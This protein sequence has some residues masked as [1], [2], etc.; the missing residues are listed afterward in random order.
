MARSVEQYQQL[1]IALLPR[2]AAWP[3]EPDSELGKLMLGVAEECRRIEQRID[4]LIEE[5]DPRTVFELIDEWE[6]DWGLPSKCVQPTTLQ[7]RRNVLTNKMI[8]IPN[9]SRQTYIDR[10]AQL[11]Y[12]ITITEYAA[13]DTVPGQPQI[14]AA[15]A[16]YVLQI[17]AGATTQQFLRCGEPIGQHF[18]TWGNELLECGLNAIK[19]SHRILIFSYT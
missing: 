8:G 19:Q 3:T 14:P 18:S 6:K 17:N 10:A 12:S 13:G 11:G 7:E 4:T 15:D 9:Q 2:G 1:L 5:S 16:A